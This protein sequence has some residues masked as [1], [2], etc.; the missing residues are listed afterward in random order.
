[1]KR[2]PKKNNQN[3]T[4]KKTSFPGIFYRE[5]CD[6]KT[7]SIIDYYYV[8][9]F[10]VN[11]EKFQVVFGS[12]NKFQWTPKACADKMA[13]FRGNAKQGVR[14]R[15]FREEQELSQEKELAEEAERKRLERE[16][17]TFHDY[18]TETYLPQ[19]KM[20]KKPVS[21]KNEESYF[22]NWIDPGMGSKSLK[23]ITAEDLEN[24]KAQMQE[25]GCSPRTIQFALSVIRQVF[26]SAI[27]SGLY[28]GQSPVRKIKWPRVG[29]GRTRFLTKH[30]ADILLN[31]LAGKSI[32][33]YETALLS[34]HTGMRSGEI[35]NLTWQDLDFE[36]GMIHITNAKDAKRDGKVRTV[37]MSGQVKEMLQRRRQLSDNI[38]VFPASNGKKRGMISK[39]FY[40]VVRKTGLNDGVEDENKKVCFHTLRHTF[41]SWQIQNGMSLYELQR[42]LGQESYAM[43]QRYAHLA[44]E[45]LKKATAVFDNP[46]N[47]VTEAKNEEADENGEN[48]I[49]EG[50]QGDQQNAKVIPFKR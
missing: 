50:N 7:G 2:I 45:N 1:M 18:F 19:A 21:Y 36:G 5:V 48:Q 22:N 35:H 3:K 13:E 39:A 34:L 46:E 44:P 23:E 4:W 29:K 11:K 41:A 42:L 15:T 9:W 20:D 14:P 49:K 6:A 25:A 32:D 30:E 24:L 40:D 33:L 31:R 28:K 10:S 26:N 37:Y 8:G 12:K 16:N 17:T 47:Q 38:Y 43:V 27:N